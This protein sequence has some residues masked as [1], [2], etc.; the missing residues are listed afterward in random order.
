MD[1]A[2]AEVGV[3]TV[4]AFL[5]I[6]ADIIDRG[7]FGAVWGLLGGLDG[8]V[9]VE[10]LLAIN[11]LRGNSET[12]EKN[13]SLSQIETAIDDGIVDAGNGELDGG[14]ILGRRKLQRSKPQVRLGAD[15]VDLGV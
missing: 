4:V 6:V 12:V 9:R 8:L 11:E 2:G 7:E 10:E 3:E 14:R 15:G 5:V 1:A 13:R